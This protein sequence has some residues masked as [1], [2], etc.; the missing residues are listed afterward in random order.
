MMKNRKK[1]E[2]DALMRDLGLP[3]S[4]D[5]R[6][7][8]DQR[9]MYRLLDNVTLIVKGKND[10]I[11]CYQEYLKFLMNSMLEAGMDPRSLTGTAQAGKILKSLAESRE[12]HRAQAVETIEDLLLEVVRSCGEESSF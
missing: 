5:S 3:T 1:I 10:I 4:M 7:S 6:M 2:D 12:V 9:L 8:D 11:K